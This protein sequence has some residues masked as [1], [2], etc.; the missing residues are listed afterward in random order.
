[1]NQNDP[2]SDIN[3]P[4]QQLT[5]RNPTSHNLPSVEVR[6]V[7]ARHVEEEIHL[8]DY[9]DVILRR[10]WTIVIVLLVIFF[11]IALY[12]FT[13]TPLYSAKGVMR[14]SAQSK[15]VTKFDNLES[16]A[17]KSIEF[18]QTQVKLF[19]SEQLANRVITNLDLT[20]NKLF[21][22][23]TDNPPQEATGF[24]NRLKRLKSNIKDIIRFEDKA[25]AQFD[26]TLKNRLLVHKVIQHFKNN[27]KV[28]P[29]RKSELIEI[30][31][32]S[33][34]A[35]LAADITNTSMN[36]FIEMHMDSRLEATKTAGIFLDKQ[37]LKAKIKLEESEK[38]LHQF[39]SSIGIVSLDPKLNL[40]MRQLEELNDALAKSRAVR[41]T[42]EAIYQQTSNTNSNDLSQILNNT[43]I[44]ELKNQQTTLQTQY[45]ELST[46]FKDGYPKMRQL[47]A[48]IKEL[49][50]RI[51]AERHRIINSIKND[52][53]SAQK[54]E[55]YL[56][57][58]A[59][60]QKKRALKLQDKATQYKIIQRE[61]Q[62]NKTVY[63]SLLQRS[64][65]IEATI[66]ADVTNIQIVDTARTPLFPSKPRV[67]LNLL[68]SVFIGLFSG[69]FIAFFQEYLDNTIKNPD[70]LSERFKIPV[71]GLIPF[72]KEMVDNRKTMALQLFNNPRSPI[73]EAIK[74]T[75]T[76]VQLSAVDKP[77][78]LILI[79]SILPG[80]GKSTF[81]TNAAL[82]YLTDG[83][84]CL[85][86]DVDLRKPSLHNI[87][88]V[89]KNQK[90][91]SSVL[92]GMSKLTEVIRASSY[93][94]LYYISS[95]PLP[96]NPAELL[97]SRSM[98]NLLSIIREKFDYVILD[99]APF[100]GFAEVLVLANMVDGVILMASE[101]DTPREGVKHFKKA[102]TNV[103]GNLIGAVLNRSGKTKSFRYGS[104]GGYKYYSY[105]Y[106]YGEEASGTTKRK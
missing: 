43:L 2:Y 57:E 84:K 53:K 90:G 3:S 29:V 91:L 22:K 56:R 59:E 33:A 9:L 93:N 19:T 83:A 21:N 46:K 39:S 66:G 5:V 15:S 31:Y 74:T 51:L 32:E 36:E 65:E 12:T 106:T 78:K 30:S 71:L 54:N 70:E 87:F 20:N 38:Q 89:E 10:R 17:L 45:K 75:M 4:D 42:K 97:S 82:S 95:G 103:K 34:D 41:I 92:S 23:Q 68:L 64:K 7:V 35:Q 18:Q 49:D 77:N 99:C 13:T 73:A 25:M 94:G 86:I 76:S 101:G 11:S 79:T 69:I 105:N 67:S 88:N 8:R 104:Y 55:D 47:I 63:Q 6:E 14:V 27:F 98:R 60:E 102:I 72:M 50:S 37:I 81:A 62:T 24:L 44:K 40:V 58:K 16:N 1:M 80:A 96:P 85:I 48:R 26:T 61:V 52:Y 28:S 100:Q